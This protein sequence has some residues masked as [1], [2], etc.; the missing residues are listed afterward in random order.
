MCILVI[1]GHLHTWLSQLFFHVFSF[2]FNIC[3]FFCFCFFILVC[4]ITNFCLCYGGLSKAP[5]PPAQRCG[6]LGKDP[7]LGAVVEECILK[8]CFE[9]IFWI[10]FP[11]H[12][13]KHFKFIFKE[14]LYKYV[15]KNNFNVF[16]KYCGGVFVV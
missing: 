4:L 9:T 5:P 6:A 10:S 11:K 7:T 15:L 2:W 13:L 12:T 3:L 1:V 14:W 16:G 8:T